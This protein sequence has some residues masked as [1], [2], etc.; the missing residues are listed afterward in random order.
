MIEAYVSRALPGRFDAALELAGVAFDFLES[1]GA[2]GC[3]LMQL[4]DAGLMSECLV[5]SWE[6][7]N[8]RAAGK[9]TDAYFTDP[10]AQSLAQIITGAD[11]PIT[12]ITSGMY[13]QIPL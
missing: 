13:T 7:E 12:P 3:R 5:V 6:F 8:V 1:H 4:N 11:S 10:S 9:A 2:V